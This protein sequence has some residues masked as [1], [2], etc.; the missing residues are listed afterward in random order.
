MTKFIAD[1]GSNHNGDFNRCIELIDKAKWAGCWGVKFQ[2]FRGNELYADKNKAKE[3]E[4]SALPSHFIPDLSAHAITA[5]LEFGAT[6]F[7]IS[8]A[9]SIQRY[10]TFVKIS[11]F[12]LLRLDLIKRCAEMHLPIIISTGMASPLEV[13]KAIDTCRGVG[14]CDITLL[15]CISRYPAMPEDCGLTEIKTMG[16]HYLNCDIGW[17]DHT[18]EPG[19]IHQAIFQGARVIEFHL[20]LD[21]TGWEAEHGHCWMPSEIKRVIYDSKVAYKAGL[22]ADAFFT[23]DGERQQRADPEDGLRPMKEVR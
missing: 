3:A 8:A 22:N 16:A 7:S 17:S 13:K 4:K 18:A 19:V 20:D 2:V 9:I 12:D 21:G 5:G 6:P 15:H 1:I 10:S 14:N 11:S 23:T